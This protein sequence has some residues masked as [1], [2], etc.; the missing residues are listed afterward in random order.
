[1][2]T[3]SGVDKKIKTVRF[4]DISIGEYFVNY[5]RYMIDGNPHLCFKVTDD[6]FLDLKT[7]LYCKVP[8]SVKPNEPFESIE[9]LKVFAVTASITWDWIVK[10]NHE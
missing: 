4:C 5:E 1:M 7:K 9:T 6:S 10:D 2:T 3:Y 8:T